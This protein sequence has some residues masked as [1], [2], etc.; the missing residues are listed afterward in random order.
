V[1]IK[2]EDKEKVFEAF[3][4]TGRSIGGSG[5]GLSVVYNLVTFQLDGN[6]EVDSTLGEGSQFIIYLP[7]VVKEKQQQTHLVKEIQKPT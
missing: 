4:T 7:K 1:G 2:D 5:I 3:Y 6:V